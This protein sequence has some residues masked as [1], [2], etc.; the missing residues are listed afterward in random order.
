[1]KAVEAE[2]GSKK[3]FII[4][5]SGNQV[6]DV[7]QHKD[8]VNL[9]YGA[10]ENIFEARG[11]AFNIGG[12]FTNSLSLLE[13]SSMLEHI[14]GCELNYEHLARRASDQRV[15]VANLTKVRNL[16]GWEPQATAREGVEG[17]VAWIK[18]NL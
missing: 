11:Q 4:S 7:L 12:G 15:F 14:C 2:R 13:F 5:G 9:Y 17:M 3:A 18:A 1:M 6:R 16:L 10:L 8:M